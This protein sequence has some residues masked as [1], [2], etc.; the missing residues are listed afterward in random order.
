MNIG[1]FNI[2]NSLQTFRWNALDWC[3]PPE[4]VRC[5]E[6]GQIWCDHC[7]KE[8]ELVQALVCPRCGSPNKAGKL[9]ITCQQNPPAFDWVRSWAIYTEPL[10]KAIHALKYKNQRSLAAYFSAAIEP[11]Y[12]S[13]PAS[14]DLM[15]VVP[16]SRKRIRERGY[17]QIAIVAKALQP[18]IKIPFLPNAIQRTRHTETQVGKSKQERAENVSGAFQANP[19]VVQDKTV[20]ILDDVYTTGATLNSCSNALRKAGARQV[21]GI[22]IARAGLYQHQSAELLG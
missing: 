3:F 10:K 14:I 8:V 2:V 5:S 4:C 6:P 9:C 21:I 7:Q 13:C 1:S 19:I 11:I 22:T 18:Q 12:H 15:T 17:N 16:L 20:L